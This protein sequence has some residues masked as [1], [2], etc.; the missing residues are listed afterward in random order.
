MKM[1]FRTEVIGIKDV[2][3]ISDT[4]LVGRSSSIDDWL[5]RNRRCAARLKVSQRRSSIETYFKSKNKW[6]QSNQE[7]QGKPIDDTRRHWRCGSKRAKKKEK[8][9]KTPVG[10]WL[11]SRRFERS[12][13]P[14]AGDNPI[15]STENKKENQQ[16]KKKSKKTNTNRSP[17]FDGRDYTPSRHVSNIY[18]ITKIE[19]KKT[20]W[21]KPCFFNWKD[22]VDCLFF[23][24]QIGSRIELSRVLALKQNKTT[25][26]RRRPIPPK[27]CSSRG[28][29]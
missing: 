25:N 8:K 9:K 4:I 12:P 13:S 5:V 16:L 28:R 1:P 19:E 10:H 15:K 6:G 24:L 26:K 27:S 21:C 17:P 14:A 11:V 22:T 7:H 2:S 3:G 29:K 23:L 20:G 18:L